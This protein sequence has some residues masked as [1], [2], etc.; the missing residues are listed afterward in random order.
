MNQTDSPDGWIGGLV[1]K[2]LT[3]ILLC[4]GL[5]DQCMNWKGLSGI[6]LKRYRLVHAFAPLDSSNF[7][8]IHLCTIDSL[9]WMD[10]GEGPTV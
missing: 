1:K 2:G 4:A 8:I 9:D 10:T 5:C 7:G 6:L 3:V